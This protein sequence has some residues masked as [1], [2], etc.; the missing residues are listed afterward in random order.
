MNLLRLLA[1]LIAV[2][3][4]ALVVFLVL[5]WVGILVGLARGWAW[6]RNFW[7]RTIHMLLMAVVAAEALG[8][9]DCPLTTWERDLRVSGG[10]EGQP[11]SFV[12]R[13]VNRVL[14]Y[15]LPQWVFRVLHCVF[16]ALV[17]LTFVLAPPRRP[18]SKKRAG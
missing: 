3:H 5:G 17:L 14:F 1:D 12:G 16:G 15:D 8:G 11:G 9:L 2:V 7:F 18:R 4:F 6:V 10:E 13:L